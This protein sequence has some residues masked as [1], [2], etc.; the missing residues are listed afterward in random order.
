MHCLELYSDTAR[1]QEIEIKFCFQTGATNEVSFYS[2]YRANAG[3]LFFSVAI[4]VVS[5]LVYDGVM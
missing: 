4:S 2:K 5:F 3:T 1:Y